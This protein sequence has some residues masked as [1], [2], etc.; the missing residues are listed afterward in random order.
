M[1]EKQWST[2]SGCVDRLIFSAISSLVSMTSS[3][4]L[5]ELT[6]MAKSANATMCAIFTK[7][8]L[9]CFGV[10]TSIRQLIKYNFFLV[11]KF[12]L[13]RAII[14]ATNSPIL[15]WL[16]FRTNNPVIFC[17]Y[18]RDLYWMFPKPR[19]IPF[20][21]IKIRFLQG[22]V[23][24]VEAVKF[25]NSATVHVLYFCSLKAVWYNRSAYQ[26]CA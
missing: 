6:T 10:V 12:V 5:S 24:V 1:S 9:L 18:F 23:K 14:F 26:I 17:A 8:F 21:S 19:P 13:T 7:T 11:K 22:F 2:A 4:L 16:T 3:E 20:R 15:L 25:Y